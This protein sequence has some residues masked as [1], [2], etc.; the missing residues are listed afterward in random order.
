MYNTPPKTL[1]DL[2]ELAQRVGAEYDGELGLTEVEA[3]G[4]I[5]LAREALEARAERDRGNPAPLEPLGVPLEGCPT[6]GCIYRR[7]HSGKCFEPG[8]VVPT[9][10]G[11]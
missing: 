6:V 9:T 7:D 2:D 8:D 10:P 11:R 3:L 5:A 4:L 1:A